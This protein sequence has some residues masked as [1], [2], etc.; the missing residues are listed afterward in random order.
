MTPNTDLQT[1]AEELDFGK[2]LADDTKERH[3]FYDILVPVAKAAAKA[4]IND[5]SETELKSVAFEA[6][7]EMIQDLP[8]FVEK[9]GSIEDLKNLVATIARRRSVD[10]WREDTGARR[11]K[12]TSDTED[13]APAPPESPNKN[14]DED[15]PSHIFEHKEQLRDAELAYRE[16]ERLGHW[17]KTFEWGLEELEKREEKMGKIYRLIIEGILVGLSI[18]QLAEKLSKSTG[19]VGSTKMRALAS[20]KKIITSEQSR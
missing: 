13:E 11:K 3:R 17:K 18:E 19:Y 1:Q 5:R 16:A 12:K 8:R 7:L 2:L 14:L 9:G 10:L 4:A 15:T 6:I 20:F